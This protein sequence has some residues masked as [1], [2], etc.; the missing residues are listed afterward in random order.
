MLKWFPD[1]QMKVNGNKYHLI[2]NNQSYIN[3]KLENLNVDN[4]TCEKL[5]GVKVDDKL[6]FNTPG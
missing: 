6:N 5:L 3:L 2:T 1:N 4:S